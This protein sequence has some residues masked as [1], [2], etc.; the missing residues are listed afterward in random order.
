MPRRIV[1]GLNAVIVSVGD[2]E[3]RVL[4]VAPAAEAESADLPSLPSGPFDPA[5]DRTLELGLRSW[6]RGRPGATS[7][8]WSSSTRSGP[9][10]ATRGSG[11]AGR[12]CCRSPTWPLTQDLSAGAAGGA[13]SCTASCPGKTGAPSARRCWTR[14]AP[15]WP[16]GGQGRTPAERAR[17]AERIEICFGLSGAGWDGYRVLERYELLYEA[18]LTHE[19]WSDRPPVA[20]A[21]APRC[22]ASP[23]PT[24]TGGSSRP[25][26]RGCAA[27]CAT[28][29]WCSS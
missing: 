8:T 23:W 14:S 17:R 26:W 28:V 12:G 5:A 3:A 19:T 16:L 2:D 6:V 25:G 24:T 10:A 9:R 29:R 4:T 13:G 18:G 7:A 21:S 20:A 22:S 1:V 27:S 15:L 11:P